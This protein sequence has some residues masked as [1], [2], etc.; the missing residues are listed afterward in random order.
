M[1]RLKDIA[2][3]ASVSVMTVSKVL[4]D[5]KDISAQTKLRVR[6]LAEEMG[7][8]P[9]ALA[10]SMRSGTTKLM[11]LIIPSVA[12]PVFA[13]VIL[14]IEEKAHEA[15]YDLLI[16]HSL[17][18][19]E[20]EESAIRRMLARRVD[21]LFIV[22]AY[23]FASTSQ[24]WDE[25]RKRAVPT[26]VLGQPAEFCRGFANVETDDIFASQIATRHLLELGHKRIAFLKGPPSSPVAQE[27]FEGYTKAMRDEGLEPDDR[28]IFA[29][30]QT[31]EE[32]TTAALQIMNERPDITALIAFNDLVAIG[33]ASTFL[34]QGVKI[35][36][37]LSIVGFGNILISEHFR[38]PLTTIR[39]PKLR[40]GISAF[41]QLARLMRGE[42]PGS[43]RLAAEIVVRDSTAAP[44]KP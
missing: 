33:A 4:R 15:G 13:R 10:Q 6:K 16:A 29:A 14:A 2:E 43:V 28:W 41:E 42:K 19:P 34:Q 24:A 31:I 21:G 30:G 32:G 37:E 12:N 25:L 36:G 17:N 8:V 23:R 22:P 20:R 5:A 26:V 35:P 39:L 9:D 40:L 7:Y 38:V 3:R 27:R 11:G 1:V 18:K 44:S